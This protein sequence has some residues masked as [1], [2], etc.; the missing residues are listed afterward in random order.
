MVSL[1]ED[2][3]MEEITDQHKQIPKWK[4][5]ERTLVKHYS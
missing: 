1:L 2:L 3:R 4:N 5:S